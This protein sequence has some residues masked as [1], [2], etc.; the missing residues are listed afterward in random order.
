MTLIIIFKKKNLCGFVQRPP[1]AIVF[2][3]FL[4]TKTPKTC[5]L[6]VSEKFPQAVRW[7]LEN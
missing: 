4:N 7:C 2:I 3:Y 5:K 6:F 1:E